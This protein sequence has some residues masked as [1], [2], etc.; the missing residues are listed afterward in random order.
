MNIKQVNRKET[1]EYLS[2]INFFNL[3]EQT[4]S[5][6]KVTGMS[7]KGRFRHSSSIFK[8]QLLVIGGG[9]N[10]VRFSNIHILDLVS[11][12]WSELS[13]TNAL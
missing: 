1:Y 12:T 7:P 3:I 5:C 11:R 10:L 4:Y 13:S 6:E 9:T 2:D 8:D